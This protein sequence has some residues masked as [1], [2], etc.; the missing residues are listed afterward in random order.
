MSA[1]QFPLRCVDAINPANPVLDAGV[2]QLV[3]RTVRHVEHL[4]NAASNPLLPHE[5]QMQLLQLARTQVAGL[6]AYTQP[7]ADFDVEAFTTTD[8]PLEPTA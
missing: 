5:L 8:S 3:A 6:E 2:L 7:W 1:S 4:L